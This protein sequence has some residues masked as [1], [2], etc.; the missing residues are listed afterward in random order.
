VGAAVASSPGL[1]SANTSI[2]ARGISIRSRQGGW[3]IQGFEQ[4]G[5]GSGHVVLGV[6]NGEEIEKL[7]QYF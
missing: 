2:P 6:L 5:A 3:V 1:A 4:S 7:D